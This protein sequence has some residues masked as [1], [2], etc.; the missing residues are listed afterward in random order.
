MAATDPDTFTRREGSAPAPGA[1]RDRTGAG[2]AHGKA[3][4]L[5]EHAVVYGAPALALPVPQLTVAAKA[6]GHR[7][8]QE[9]EEE[10]SFTMSGPQ[11]ASAAPP[12]T[13]GL[14]RLV[15]EFKL[16]TGPT[17]PVRVDVRV[18]CAIPEGRGLGSSAACARAV[19]LALADLFERRLDAGAVFDLVQAS[20]NVAHGRASGIDAVATGSSSLV[21]FRSGTVKELP[22]PLP[23]NGFVPP[24]GP[25]GGRTGGFDGLFVI[26]DSGVSGS[27]R[28]AVE[29]LR[30]RFERDAGTRTDFVSRAADLTDAAVRALGDGR[31]GELGERMTENHELLHEAGLS[32]EAIDTLVGAALAAGGLGAKISGGGLGGCM[33]A[34]AGEPGHAEEVVRSLREAG[35]VRTWV[36]PVGRFARHAD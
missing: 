7:W 32:T 3:I 21:L 29:L 22:V 2:R 19:V 15:A 1:R 11:A 24:P 12:A 28:E 16:R 27:T 10:V 33:I 34:L 5:G 14:R 4:L 26:A 9:G 18:D 8:G 35:A 30:Q 23:G 31:P 6:T 17:G 36:V 13:E 25:A 20:E